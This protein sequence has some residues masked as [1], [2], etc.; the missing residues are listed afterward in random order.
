MRIGRSSLLFLN[1]KRVLV[2][3]VNIPTC[4][5]LIIMRRRN[6]GDKIFED[7]VKTLYKRATTL[8]W[9]VD[10]VL[11]VVLY[12]LLHF[13]SLKYSMNNNVEPWH[14]VFAI[15]FFI[16]QYFIPVIFIFGGIAS[17]WRVL[18]SKI[19]G[20][21][22][23]QSANARGATEVVSK[24]NWLDFEIFI[25]EWFSK[26]GYS[27]SQ[28]GGADSGHAHADGGVDVELHKDGELFLVQCKHYRSWK[29]SVETVRDLYGV[30]TSRGAVGGFVVT[31]GH[32]TKPAIEFSLG[33]SITLIDGDKLANMI[34]D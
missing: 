2:C 20:K 17:V 32:F 13:L 26:Q 24:M 18:Q 23:F 10:L 25:G 4:Y 16:G 7:I 21:E 6:K 14:F 9:Y 34:K 8:P 33:R 3:S 11:A 5:Y 28:A 30:M 31:S 15:S 1:L 19:R 22:L 27:V 12:F 29:V